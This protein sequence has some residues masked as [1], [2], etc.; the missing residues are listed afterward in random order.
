MK[1]QEKVLELCLMAM[2]TAVSVVLVTTIRFPLIPAANFLEYEPADIPVLI[3]GMML[4]PIHGLIILLVTCAIQAITVS[5]TSGIIGFLMHFI[6]SSAL[7]LVVSLIYRKKKT[8]LSLIIGL[9]A[10]SLAMTAVMIPLNI[11]FIPLLF[12]AV[13]TETVIGMLIPAIIP[14]NLLKAG[15]NSVITFAVFTPIAH[16]LKK[17][18]KVEKK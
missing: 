10:G 4:G 5:S 1:K 16:V 12:P 14:F 7:V 9:I 15:I 8:V 3:G 2:L 11:I 13:T 18:I 6:A 17:Y